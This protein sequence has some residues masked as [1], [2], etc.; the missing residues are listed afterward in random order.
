MLLPRIVATTAVLATAL[1]ITIISS[2][3]VAFSNNFCKKQQSSRHIIITSSSPPH[4]PLLLFA[5]NDD[6]DDYDDDVLN[7]N[8]D[9]D[10][11]HVSSII[12]R[13]SF[14]SNIAAGTSIIYSSSSLITSSA[15]YAATDDEEV[16][17][18]GSSFESIAARAARVS[19][20]VEEAEIAKEAADETA[21]QRRKDAAQ[22]LKDDKRNIYDFMLPING[23]AREVA[24]V[25]GQTF[26]E[27]ESGDGWSGGG[28][29]MSDYGTTMGTRVKA[30]LV[31]NIKQDDP[32]A[33]KNI[34][35]LIALVSK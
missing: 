21:T 30:I 22:K 10:N 32:I 7:R 18:G 1:I 19:V 4:S 16:E 27:G 2:P 14:L 25:I 9:S 8:G 23:K 35:E 20:E 24:E 12:Q 29:G 28:E 15:S 5:H 17:S 33:R 11:T 34:P 13:R 3:C 6:D 26:D 31:V